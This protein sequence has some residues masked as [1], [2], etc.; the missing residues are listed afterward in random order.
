[1]KKRKWLPHVV[2][3]VALAVFTVLGLAS[4]SGSPQQTAARQQTQ[5][6]WAG[7]EVQELDFA[8]FLEG[9]LEEGETHWFSIRARGDFVI[10]GVSTPETFRLRA[11]DSNGIERQDVLGD[12]RL[13]AIQTWVGETYFFSLQGADGFVSNSYHIGARDQ[14]S[15]DEGQEEARRIAAAEAEEAR[16]RALENFIFAPSDFNPASHTSVDLFRAAADARDLP[17]MSNRQEAMSNQAGVDMF[18]GMGGGMSAIA[19]LAGSFILRYASD[20]T[21]VRQNGLDI[22]FSSDA[23]DITQTMTIDRSSGLQAGQ[24]I[25]VYY[26]VMRIPLTTWDVVAIE[27]R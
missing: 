17:I 9:N 26:T 12:A 11:F 23:N 18:A 22:T 7:A 4:A 25:R 14:R 6:P 24:R 5:V 13:I 21:F 8:T 19:N 20:L 16:L 10:V 27:P 1:M 2:A 3:V 15:T